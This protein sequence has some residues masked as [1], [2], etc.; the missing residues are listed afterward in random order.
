VEVIDG[1]LHDRQP[2]PPR[3]TS[4]PGRDLSFMVKLCTAGAGG[5]R[6]R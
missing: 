3:F 4:K 5:M 6:E 1:I 2:I